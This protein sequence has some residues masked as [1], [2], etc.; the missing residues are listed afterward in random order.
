MQFL[1]PMNGISA[2][3]SSIS[4]KKNKK[5][6]CKALSSCPIRR[7]EGLGRKGFTLIELILVILLLGIIG[8]M[9]GEMIVTAFK[10]FSDTDARMELFEEGEMA[11]MR[12]ERE[13]HHMIPNAIDNPDSSTISFGLIDVQAL[14]GVFG[15]YERVDDDTIH[16]IGNT[17]LAT[18]SLISIYNTNWAEFSSTNAG[19]RKI[20]GTTAAGGNMNLH[21]AL[22]DGESA[23]R[24]YYPVAKAVRYHVDGSV[25]FRSE[26]AVTTAGDFATALT[27]AS[28]YPLLSNITNFSFSYSPATLTRNALVRINFTL[29]NKGN[30]LDFH[31]EI[32]VRNVP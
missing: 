15:E 18:G 5:L 4:C 22:I 29:D 3:R 20:Y 7:P 8:V 2:F 6:S 1:T 26:I 12:M 11:L 19:I 13:I 31:K 10:G 24:R 9:G 25:L 23:T 21:K 28:A 14:R 30:S 17:V 32:Q 27:T 16:D